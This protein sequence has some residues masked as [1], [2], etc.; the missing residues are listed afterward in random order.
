LDK[1]IPTPRPLTS[2]PVHIKYHLCRNGQFD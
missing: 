2:S 1:I